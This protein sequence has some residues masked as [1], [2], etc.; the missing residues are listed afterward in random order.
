MN[1]FPRSWLGGTLRL[2]LYASQFSPCIVHF[3]RAVPASRL[4]YG[5]AGLTRAA[6]GGGADHLAG[7]RGSARTPASRLERSLSGSRLR[8]VRELGPR[9]RSLRQ[10]APGARNRQEPLADSGRGGRRDRRISDLRRFPRPVRRAAE[11]SSRLLQ[12]GADSDVSRGRA[13]RPAERAFQPA[14][15]RLANR[16][17]A[18]PGFRRRVHVPRITT[19]W[20]TLP[21]RSATFRSPTSTRPA[22]TS[23]SSSTPIRRLRHGRRSSPPC[24]RSSPQRPVG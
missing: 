24:T 10:S 2:A 17:S 22:A 18:D 13:Q 15:R 9:Q 11:P 8:P 12:S 1:F 16:H 7:G 6:S 4:V 3:A 23:A 5:L 21:S 19:A 20:S 14:S